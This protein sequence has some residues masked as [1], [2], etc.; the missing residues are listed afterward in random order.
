MIWVNGSMVNRMPYS[1]GSVSASIRQNCR[2]PVRPKLPPGLILAAL[3]QDDL[4]DECSRFSLE[5]KGLDLAERDIV[6][7]G[8]ERS[9]FSQVALW[10]SHLDRASFVDVEFSNC[11]LANIDCREISL[12]RTVLSSCRMTGANFLECGVRDVL[13]D[14]NRMDLASFRFCK[15]GRVKFVDCKLAKADFQGAI[16]KA[17][18]FERCDLTGAQFSQADM[19]GAYLS[20]C[21]LYGVNGVS[22]MKGATVRMQDMSTLVDSLATALGIL[23]DDS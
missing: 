2:P 10:D 14:S 22:G 20:D 15:F 19:A 6:L 16:L 21:I 5:Y 18:W 13:F 23:I 7:T 17:A 8:V 4:A 11:D 1:R 3:P 9:R 12:V